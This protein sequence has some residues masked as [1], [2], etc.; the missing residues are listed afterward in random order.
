MAERADSSRA[1]RSAQPGFLA[2]WP[3][4]VRENRVTRHIESL[5]VENPAWRRCPNAQDACTDKNHGRRNHNWAVHEP[6]GFSRS[7]V[8]ALPG[9]RLAVSPL[10]RGQFHTGRN[11]HRSGLSV[12]QPVLPGSGLAKLRA[13]PGQAHHDELRRD[14]RPVRCADQS[15]HDRELR[16]CQSQ[17][18]SMRAAPKKK[19]RRLS[20]AGLL[21]SLY[22]SSDQVF[23]AS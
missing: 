8:P 17:P 6:D 16:S 2:R 18:Q 14:Q 9:D 3:E 12:S 1:R 13:R 22:L 19:P 20:L 4:S 21:I 11:H 23:D 10:W 15:I 7:I 5:G